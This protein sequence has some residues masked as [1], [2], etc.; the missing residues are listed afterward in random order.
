M[1]STGSHHFGVIAEFSLISS[2]TRKHKNKRFHKKFIILWLMQKKGVA[3]KR[4]NR[5]IVMLDI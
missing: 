2:E 5:M 3:F 1:M 4:D